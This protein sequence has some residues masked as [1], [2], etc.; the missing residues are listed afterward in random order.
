MPDSTHP[1]GSPEHSFKLQVYRVTAVTLFLALLGGALFIPFVYETQTLWY[2]TGVD[3]LMLR[4]AQMLGLL[5]AVLLFVQVL[6]ATRGRLLQKLFGMAALMRYHRANGILISFLVVGHVFLVLVPE[7]LTNLPLGRKNWPE[8][9][10][11]VLLWVLLSMAVSSHFRERLK[12]DY[13]R[14]RAIHKILGYLV[15]FL[16]TMHVLFVSQSFE[17]TLPK[18]AFLAVLVAVLLAA[19]RSKM[20]R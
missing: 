14:W 13:K 8:L 20:A 17:E 1:Q 5:A 3:K 2:K 7:G 12:L 19:I 10:G 11:A 9:V 4:A 15:L 6:L 18:L 16:L